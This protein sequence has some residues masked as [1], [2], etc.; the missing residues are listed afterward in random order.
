M[1]NFCIRGISLTALC[2]LSL[3]FLSGCG[4]PSSVER[5][6]YPMPPGAEIMDGEIGVHGGRFIMASNMEPKTFNFLVSADAGTRQVT[7][8]I[9]NGLTKVD[10]YEGGS[11]HRGRGA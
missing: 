11:I 5:R 9:F 2:T 3:P 8:L 10:P 7:G 6:D 1:K 4:K